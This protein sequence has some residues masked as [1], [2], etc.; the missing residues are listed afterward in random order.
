MRNRTQVPV[1][2]AADANGNVLAFLLPTCQKP[3]RVCRAPCLAR[4]TSVLVLEPRASRGQ[5]SHSSSYEATISEEEM[6]HLCV[7]PALL[8]SR[9]KC[10]PEPFLLSR[11]LRGSGVVRSLKKSW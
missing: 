8:Q 10:S 2:I 9:E 1:Q 7:H 6:S 11:D 4:W 3:G 5:L